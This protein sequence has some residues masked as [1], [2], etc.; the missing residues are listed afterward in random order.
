MKNDDND[1][2]SSKEDDSV[3]TSK[4]NRRAGGRVRS[5]ILPSKKEPAQSPL[6]GW[7]K[8]IL[9]P[10]AAL[11]ILSQLIF[12][13]ENSS[14]PNYYYYQSSVY[15]SSV[16]GPNGRV[17]T[18]TKE[19]VRTN[20]P[21]LGPGQEKSRFPVKKNKDDSFFDYERRADE[22]FDLQLDQEIESMMRMQRKFLN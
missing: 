16:Y 6:P 5:K 2:S 13:G 9:I 10:V 12:G 1:P 19:S 22:E 14:S 18:A 17:D 21:G 7:V 3:V 20:M 11:W 4:S 15:Q 8:P